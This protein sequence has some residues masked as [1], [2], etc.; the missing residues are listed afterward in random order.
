LI[1]DLTQTQFISAQGYAAIGD[2]SLQVPVRV[3]AKTGLASKV[4]A[5]YGFEQVAIAVEREPAVNPS[6]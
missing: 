5:I 4:L 3:H 6:C 2:C 1:F